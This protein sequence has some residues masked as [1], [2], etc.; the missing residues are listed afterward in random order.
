DRQLRMHA[1]P[2][3]AHAAQWPQVA[4]GKY[5]STYS[6][7][8]PATGWPSPHAN[9]APTVDTR[10]WTQ[11][12]G[13]RWQRHGTRGPSCTESHGAAPVH[14]GPRGRRRA[15]AAGTEAAITPPTVT[16]APVVAT[17]GSALH[18]AA[19]PHS[20][21]TWHPH[22]DTTGTTR[23]TVARRGHAATAQQPAATPNS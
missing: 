7:P 19:T 1:H 14:R 8:N 23:A 10:T 2:P 18:H 20:E 5:S 4:H 13:G 9:A 3:C 21:H 22:A 15:R 16:A 12:L 6:R 17:A 11:Q